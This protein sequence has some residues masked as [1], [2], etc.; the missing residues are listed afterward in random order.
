MRFAGNVPLH[1]W[2]FSHLSP[3]MLVNVDIKVCASI[4]ALDALFSTWT[5]GGAADLEKA[6]LALS[7]IGQVLIS[8][9]PSP[10]KGLSVLML[11]MGNVDS[12]LGALLRS[13]QMQSKRL[14]AFSMLVGDP[15]WLEMAAHRMQST[16]PRT[17][18][19]ALQQTATLESMKY[20]VW[21]GIDR[22]ELK[23]WGA[24]RWSRLAS[25][26]GSHSAWFTTCQRRS[27]LRRGDLEVR[28]TFTL[29]PTQPILIGAPVASDPHAA[30]PRRSDLPDRAETIVAFEEGSVGWAAGQWALTFPGGSPICFRISWV[31]HREGGDWQ[32]VHL[33]VSNPLPKPRRLGARP[34]HFDRRRRRPRRTRTPRADRGRVARRNRHDHVH[35][36]RGIY[37]VERSDGRRQFLPLLLAHNEIVRTRTESAGGIVVKSQGDG[38]M[39]A[40]PSARRGVEC[41]TA[42][43][44]DLTVLDDRLKVRIGLH[45]G[46]PVRHADDFYGRDVAYAARIASAARGGR[47]SCRHWCDPLWRRPA[48]S[49]SKAPAGTS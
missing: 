4:A 32:V 21:V 22:G 16:V 46:E 15:D 12:E 40:F 25:C 1:D 17:T 7:D 29:E 27:E 39:L 41:A 42:L 13:S 8:I 48:R 9:G 11:A 38:F 14:S 19:N 49:L 18:W 24:G 31:F 33:H 6:R 45:T 44:D 26:G 5:A 36:S 30:D 35:G 2:R 47:S 43:Q 10:G 3:A 23:R 34:H 20:D 28:G 37:R